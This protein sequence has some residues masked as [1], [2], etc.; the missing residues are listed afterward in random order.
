MDERR[1]ELRMKWRQVAERA[2]LTAFHLQRIRA[3]KVKLSKDAAVAIDDAM[4]WER[5]S[6][7][8]VYYEDGDPT[9][10]R[11]EHSPP[12]MQPIPPGVA[13]TPAQWAAASEQARADLIAALDN[14]RGRRRAAPRGA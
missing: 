8:T 3:G 1:V 5:G 13:I 6:A 9:P 11:R 10:L 12:G 2:D 14:I 7:W 4:A